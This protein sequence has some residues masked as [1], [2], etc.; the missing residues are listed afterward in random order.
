M[1][2]LNE[3]YRYLVGAPCDCSL[4]VLLKETEEE[5]EFWDLN[6]KMKVIWK[7]DNLPSYFIKANKLEDYE[8]KKYK[9]WLTQQHTEQ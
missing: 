2:E 3:L 5:L 4:G 1:Y 8:E 7:K 9:E 6:Y